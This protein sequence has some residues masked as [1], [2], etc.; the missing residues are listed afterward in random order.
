[1]SLESRKTLRKTLPDG[2]P[3]DFASPAYFSTNLPTRIRVELTFTRRT[4]IRQYTFP[5]G[6][7]QPRTVVDITNDGPRTTMQ[8]IQGGSNGDPILR[9]FFVKYSEQAVALNLINAAN[10]RDLLGSAV[11]SLR[12]P[13]S[14]VHTE[15]FHPTQTKDPKNSLAI[16]GG[17]GG[18]RLSHEY[19]YVIQSS[20][21]WKE[22]LHDMFH[23]WSLAAEH[24]L[25]DS[26]SYRLRDTTQGLNRVQPSSK[27][28]RLMHAILHKAQKSVSSWVGS[29][30]IHMGGHNVPNALLFID[31]YTQIYRILLPICNTLSQIPNFVMAGMD[32]GAGM[33]YPD[34][35]I[36]PR[37]LQP[38]L[39]YAVEPSFNSISVDGDKSTK[40]R[41]YFWL[42]ALQQKKMP[43][44]RELAD[45]TVDLAE[46]VIRDGQGATK[47][48]IAT[49][50]GAPTYEDIH[51]VAFRIST[52]A[53]VKTA[54]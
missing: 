1:M 24:L 35:A 13:Y 8:F 49:V 17:K 5:A 9:E 47:F 10:A 45:F 20:T 4:A 34:M 22:I 36:S 23:L 46:L 26:I 11:A 32:K 40:I 14:S 6:T 28:S 2:S 39:T 29:S 53:L 51:H 38:V 44:K 25:S 48:V 37:N 43:S 50:K 18:A 16:P 30:V 41:F 33:I 21:L 31:K 42:T 15:Y 7:S 54:L 52:S 12:R 19:A 27:T 3:D